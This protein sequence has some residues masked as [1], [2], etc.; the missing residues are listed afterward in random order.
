[1]TEKGSGMKEDGGREFEARVEANLTLMLQ[2]MEDI[3]KRVKERK[4]PPDPGEAI[5]AQAMTATELVEQA[6]RIAAS[7]ALKS[8]PEAHAKM[9]DAAAARVAE[10]GR[11][12]VEAARRTLSAATESVRETRRL[13][14]HPYDQK[15]RNWGCAAGGVLVSA[16]LWFL[17]TA[18]FFEPANSVWPYRMVNS[19]TPWGVGWHILGE[20]NSGF[21]DEID[22]A[23]GIYRNNS[24]TFAACEDAAKSRG[25]PVQCRFVVP[26][27]E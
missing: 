4:V 2:A 21:R 9:M 18:Y 19:V 16:M 13:T 26:V 11:E 20:A 7:E 6:N 1:M 25:T 24:D 14:R 17:A 3:R 22:R 23:Y 27:P 8:T 15:A 12:N 5:G 10:Q